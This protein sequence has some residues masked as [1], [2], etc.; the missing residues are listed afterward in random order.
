MVA[1]TI[2]LVLVTRPP[3]RPSDVLA[4][5]PTTPHGDPPAQP[6]GGGNVA[7]KPGPAGGRPATQRRQ[8]TSERPF[9]ERVAEAEVIVVASL[10]DFAPAPP[11]RPGDAAEVA[12]RWKV[13]RILKGKLADKIITTQK[14]GAPVGGAVEELVGKEW[15]LL[16][17]PGYMAG[18]HPY[19]GLWTIKLEREVRAIVSGGGVAP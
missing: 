13:V 18:K 7:H 4:Q 8:E 17:T 3:D 12:I 1:A 10:V 19:A 6:G 16:L 9:A 14:P 2:T 5:R 11:R 15:I